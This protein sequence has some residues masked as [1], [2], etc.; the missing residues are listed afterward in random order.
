[1]VRQPLGSA[2]QEI[3]RFLQHGLAPITDDEAA[4]VELGFSRAYPSATGGFDP[5]IW[6]R[7]VDHGYHQ[8]SGGLRRVLIRQRA[9]LCSKRPR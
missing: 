2:K 8:T 3:E 1:M 7:S 6:E 5:T 4:L 9:F